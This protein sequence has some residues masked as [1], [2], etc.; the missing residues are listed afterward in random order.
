[1]MRDWALLIFTFWL[2]LVG[3]KRTRAAKSSKAPA[4]DPMAT[5]AAHKQAEIG[6]ES[7]RFAQQQ[8]ADQKAESESMRPMIE[9]LTQ[10]QI[11]LN[12]LSIKQATEAEQHYNSTFKPLETRF[13]ADAAVAGNQSEQDAAAARAGVDV[14]R[15]IDNQFAARGREMA[16]MGVRPD[17]GAGMDR[18]SSI[19]AAAAKVGAQTGAA[20][21]ERARGDQMRQNAVSIGRGIAGHSLAATGVGTSTAG[22]AANIG[23]T[24]FN[25][26]ERAGGALMSG[27]GQATN[28]IGQ[29]AQTFLNVNGANMATWQANQQGKN[30]LMGALGGAAGMALG[31]GFGTALGGSLFGKPPAVPS[32]RRLKRNIKVVGMTQGGN[33]I[34]SYEYVW[35]EPGRGVMADEVPEAAVTGAFGFK[36]VDYSMVA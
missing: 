5:W 3:A 4:V 10:G 9:R 31:G 26:N 25:M 13:A 7:L 6:Q 15:E 18:A 33:F 16:S 22:A 27:Y 36:K 8:Y 11:D 14:Q 24:N 28:Q 29:S 12:D 35:G 34:Y 20:A 17:S 1:M 21:M 19:R 23:Q 30:Q 32:D 2:D